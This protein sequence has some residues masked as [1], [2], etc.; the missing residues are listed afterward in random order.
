MHAIT[1]VTLIFLPGTFLAVGSPFR[2]RE[3]REETEEILTSP[4]RQTFFG[5][6]LFQFDTE[7]TLPFPRWKGEFFKLF[8]EICA[9]LMGCIALLWLAV[10]LSTRRAAQQQHK[11]KEQ[12]NDL[13]KG[14]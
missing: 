12:E 6:G 4:P 2:G 8:L 1:V 9:P 14:S 5:S 10:W 3:G 7:G 13:E 11:A